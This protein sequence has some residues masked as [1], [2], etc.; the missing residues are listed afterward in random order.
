[1]RKL[2][3]RIEDLELALE[4]RFCQPPERDR[5]ED[6]RLDDRIV[7][8]DEQDVDAWREKWAAEL[9]ELERFN[10]VLMARHSGAAEMPVERKRNTPVPT[11]S[12]EPPRC[13]HCGRELPVDSYELL[14]FTTS[15]ELDRMIWL[16]SKILGREPPPPS[17]GPILGEIVDGVVNLTPRSYKDKPLA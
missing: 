15:E 9:G 11:P 16:E 5:D 3:T 17:A 1:M 7:D 2:S 12:T 6:D 13:G 8:P 10:K 4:C 14:K